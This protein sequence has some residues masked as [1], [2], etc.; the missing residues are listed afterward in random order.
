MAYKS[1]HTMSDISQQKAP[2]LSD[3]EKLVSR[4]VHKPKNFSTPDATLPAPGSSSHNPSFK[5]ISRKLIFSEHESFSSPIH[6]QEPR[7]EEQ[8][9]ESV[10]F[11]FTETQPNTVA[12][13]STIFH[14]PLP[15]SVVSLHS[16]T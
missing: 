14:E 15:I 3:P 5:D 1:S 2:I 8:S 10:S 9:F 16:S 12:G 6:F 11:T 7:L 4:K 13:T